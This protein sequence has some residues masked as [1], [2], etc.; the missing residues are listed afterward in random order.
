MGDNL[1][2]SKSSNLSVNLILKNIF[3]E[4]FDWCLTKYL[5]HSLAKLI[6][7]IN[8]HRLPQ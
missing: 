1:L 4:I 3:T 2:Y 8:H 7:N 6:Q 5:G